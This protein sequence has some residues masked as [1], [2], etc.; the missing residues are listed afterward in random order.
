LWLVHNG[1]DFDVA[2]SLSDL[3]RA[4][5]SIVMSEFQGNKFNLNT[6]RWEEQKP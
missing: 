2:F 6:M 3:D 5:W 4:A 1:I